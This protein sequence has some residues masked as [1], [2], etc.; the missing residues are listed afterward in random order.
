MQLSAPFF[1]LPLSFD[2][3]RLRQEAASLSESFCPHPQG[4]QGSDSVPLVTPGGRTGDDG[5]IGPMGP[6]QALLGCPYLLQIM[7]SLQTTIGRARIMR[8]ADKSEVPLHRDT[9]YYWLR[10]MRLHI[11]IVTDPNIIFSC[12]D[13]KVHMAAGE[14]WTLNNATL[15]GVSNPSNVVRQH[16]VI[17]TDGSDVIWNLLKDGRNQADLKPSLLKFRPG[18]KPQLS[19]EQVNSSSVMPPAEI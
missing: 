6:T 7:E 2:L 8:L 5:L 14:C 3:E 9:S 13:E 12:A 11:P 17:D 19:F 18:H 1:K 10:R 15:H 16:L 4:F